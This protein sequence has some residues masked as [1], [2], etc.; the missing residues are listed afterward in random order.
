MN[1]CTRCNSK[2]ETELNKMTSKSAT[3]ISFLYYLSIKTSFTHKY[4]FKNSWTTE[5][6]EQK[7]KRVK[8]DSEVPP[9]LSPSMRSHLESLANL[10]GE[11]VCT[12]LTLLIHSLIFLLIYL[13]SP[14][15]FNLI[16][17]MS[18]QF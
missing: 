8:A 6:S 5:G 18:L 3:Y 10:K 7:K 14:Y 12:Q 15:G 17:K 1:Y 9:R 13:S 11:Q 16:I 2:N 4:N